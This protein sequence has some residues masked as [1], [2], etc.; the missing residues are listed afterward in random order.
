[1]FDRELERRGH[2]FVRYADDSNIYVRSERAGQ[3]VMRLRTQ[4]WRAKE[5]P[6]YTLAYVPYAG[7]AKLFRILRNARGADRFNSLGPVATPG[8]YVAAVENIAPSPSS[9]TGTGG[10]RAAGE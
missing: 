9:I 6:P 7:L 2:R 8:G 4:T 3:R 5:R 10:A 1:E